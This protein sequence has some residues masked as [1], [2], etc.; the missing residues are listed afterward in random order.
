MECVLYMCAGLNRFKVP[1]WYLFCENM[2][3]FNCNHQ[4]ILIDI[5]KVPS[6][7]K[8]ISNVQM[9]RI[10]VKYERIIFRHFH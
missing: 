5:K 2:E 4:L 7:L 9:A 10:N 6:S 1:E 8:M 3:L